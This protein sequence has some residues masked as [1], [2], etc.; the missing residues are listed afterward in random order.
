MQRYTVADKS[1]TSSMAIVQ[2]RLPTGWKPNEDSIQRLMN[3][4]EVLLKRYE[5]AENTVSF[6]FDEVQTSFSSNQ[7][8]Y[9]VT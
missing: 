8:Q 5:L 9:I 1:A 7:V 6:Y 4:P 2:M 3:A